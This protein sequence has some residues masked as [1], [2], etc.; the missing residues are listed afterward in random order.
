ML[1]S[2]D[3]QRVSAEEAALVNLLGDAANEQ[4]WSIQHAYRIAQGFQRLLGAI[5]R[6]LANA[7]FAAP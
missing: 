5:R 4:T 6:G 3:E 2:S 7:V 1:A